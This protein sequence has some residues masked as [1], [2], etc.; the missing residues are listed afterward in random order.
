[1]GKGPHSFDLGQASQGPLA[2][3]ASQGVALLAMQAM[4]CGGLC[5]PSPAPL[6]RFPE[7]VRL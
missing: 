1:M 4:H 2:S 6:R 7:R 5:P 3:Q